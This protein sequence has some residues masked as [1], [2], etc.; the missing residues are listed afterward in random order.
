[1]KQTPRQWLVWAA[2]TMTV[3]ATVWTALNDE[4][5]DEVQVAASR[6][7]GSR[8]DVKGLPKSRTSGESRPAG[9]NSLDVAQ[10]Q[11]APWQDSEH[12]LFGGG[13]LVAQAETAQQPIVQQA[14]EIPPVP[15]TYAGKLEDHGQFTVFLSL[16]EKNVSVKIGDIVGDWKIKEI[17]PSRMILSYQ[18]L[19]ADVPLMIGESN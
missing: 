7:Q 8:T 14:M 18:P 2:L 15:F 5:A 11:R 16:G 6:P 12:N 13:Q 17:T 19:R 10:L 3:A 9:A 1:M 4:Q